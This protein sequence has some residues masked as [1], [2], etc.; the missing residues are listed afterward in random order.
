MRRFSYWVVLLLCGLLPGGALLWISRDMVAVER[1]RQRLEL[2]A[3]I[4]ERARLAL[5]RMESA[6]VACVV[7]ESTRSPE[8]FTPVLT[9]L[10]FLRTLDAP[11]VSLLSSPVLSQ[12]VPDVKLHFEINAKNQVTSPQAP[13][14]EIGS[15]ARRYH[16]DIDRTEAAATLTRLRSMLDARPAAALAEW[17][18][19]PKTGAINQAAWISAYSSIPS[20]AAMQSAKRKK[21]G[22]PESTQEGQ[23]F[24]LNNIED[25]QRNRLARSIY[26]G[27]VGQ[28]KQEP[29]K[30]TNR[31]EMSPVGPTERRVGTVPK[32]VIYADA[33]EFKPLWLG[34][35]LF[36]ARRV[37]RNEEAVTQGVWLDWPHL[38]AMWKES[39]RDLFPNAELVPSSLSK[40]EGGHLL[41]SLPVRLVPGDIAQ[42]PRPYW[43]PLKI[44]LG[45]AWSFMGLA[46]AAA[47][48]ALWSILRLSARRAEFVSSVTH[49]LRTPLATF[50]LYSEMLADGMVPEP[51]RQKAY[52]ETLSK[53]ADRLGHLVENVLSYSRIERGKTPAVMSSCSI[54]D[55]LQ[56][57][58]EGINQRALHA[59][60]D[61][62]FDCPSELTSKRVLTEPSAVAQI[63]FNLADNA[64]KYG[65]EPETMGKMELSVREVGKYMAF[66]LRD[67]GPGIASHE[68]RRLFKPFHKTAEAAAHS[69]PGVGLGLS[70]CRRL[71]ASLKGRLILETAQGPGATFTLRL[72]R[73]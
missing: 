33:G 52:L 3:Q 11:T 50:K 56:P 44:S 36:L 55:L 5:W 14:G 28:F 35:E 71:S 10:E 1:T 45:I 16:A 12:R 69:A 41:A 57:I 23:N 15:W 19:M 47:A 42:P 58:V 13:E 8:H 63:L 18:L 22:K 31:D 67:Y 6:A 60:M 53:E 2:G 40:A 43:T 72:L 65:R 34:R 73:A 26:N 7:A 62:T 70:L 25:E 4:D 54:E 29:K 46:V 64:C 27:N 59:G 30:V 38:Q 37:L 32:T 51:A 68:V 20:P 49:E 61:F 9:R 17:S 48:A 21:E 24:S 66:S 39:V